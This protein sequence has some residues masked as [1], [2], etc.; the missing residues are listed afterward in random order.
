MK[1]THH[2]ISNFIFDS[3]M[4]KFLIFAHAKFLKP[5]FPLESVGEIKIRIKRKISR[6]ME[7]IYIG[8]KLT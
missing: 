7:R 2:M 5:F 3:V 1:Y 6:R 8:S 4:Q